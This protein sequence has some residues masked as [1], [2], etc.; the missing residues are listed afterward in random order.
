MLTVSD[1]ENSTGLTATGLTASFLATAV[2]VAQFEPGFRPGRLVYQV[3][4]VLRRLQ[5][6]RDALT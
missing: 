1:P 5:V 2:F 6:S 4:D 3:E